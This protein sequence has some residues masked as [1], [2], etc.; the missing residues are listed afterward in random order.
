MEKAIV[1]DTNLLVLYLV[2]ATDLEYIGKHRRLYPTYSA[3]HFG[4]VR[5]RLLRASKLICTTH[6]LTEASNLARQIANP[7]RS[8][9]TATLKRFIDLAEERQVPGIQATEEPF[10]LRL[11]LT[12]AAILSLDP[13]GVQ[14]LTVD[15]DL[16]IAALEKGF[17]VHNLTPYLFE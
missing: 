13:A 1:I 6:V 14:V 15:H 4:L 12:D 11:G 3:K 17:D 5:S 2:G 8:E 16:H 10:F 7:M 9:I